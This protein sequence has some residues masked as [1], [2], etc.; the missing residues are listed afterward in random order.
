M[1]PKERSIA[2]MGYRLV[3]KSCLSIQFVAGQ[4]VDLYAIQ[5]EYTES[6][7]ETEVGGSFKQSSDTSGI[8]F[9]ENFEGK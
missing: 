7:N 6:G 2:M 1:P 4:F 9:A 3:G 8:E 5:F